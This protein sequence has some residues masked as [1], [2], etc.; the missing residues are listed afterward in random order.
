MAEKSRAFGEQVT[1]CTMLNRQ[2]PPVDLG[3][4]CFVLREDVNIDG[5]NVKLAKARAY[6]ADDTMM[7]VWPKLHS[8]LCLSRYGWL[9]NTSPPLATCSEVGWRPSLSIVTVEVTSVNSFD[10]DHDVDFWSCLPTYMLSEIPHR[11]AS[12]RCSHD[13]NTHWPAAVNLASCQPVD[14]G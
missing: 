7:Q 2:R 6:F 14:L 10:R 4:V 12:T 5:I 8:G 13:L 1:R 11:N 3:D 9:P